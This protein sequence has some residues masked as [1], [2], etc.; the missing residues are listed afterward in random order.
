VYDI[1]TSKIEAYDAASDSFLP[2]AAGEPVPCA[3][4]RGRY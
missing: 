3:T 2:L 1:E 4:P